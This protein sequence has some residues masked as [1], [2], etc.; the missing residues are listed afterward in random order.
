MRKKRRQLR[1]LTIPPAAA[2]G[3]KS[4]ELVRAWIVDDGLHCSL[5]PGVWPGG[6][7]SYEPIGWGLLLA[8]VARHAADA[9]Y[10]AD[11]R[12]GLLHS[13]SEACF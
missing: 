7:E 6:G 5:R 10:Q 4:V 9:L 3:R 12:Q 8:D 11:R 13:P 2:D 1:E